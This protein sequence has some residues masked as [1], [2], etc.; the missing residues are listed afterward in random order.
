[1]CWRMDAG[2]NSHPNSSVIVDRSW[3]IKVHLCSAVFRADP[4]DKTHA[5][6]ALFASWHAMTR[7]VL[8]ASD[9]GQ[10]AHAWPRVPACVCARVMSSASSSAAPPVSTTEPTA[11][12]TYTDITMTRWAGE[13]M[14][15]ASYLQS[16]GWMF[17]CYQSFVNYTLD[18]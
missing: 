15:W 10:R 11:L 9:A 14:G 7:C 1:M 13:I 4:A 18:H 3:H 17:N 8:A 12:L 5:W 16:R 2:R 6:H